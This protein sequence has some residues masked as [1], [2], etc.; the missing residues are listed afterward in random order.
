[1]LAQFLLAF[2][3]NLCSICASYVEFILDYARNIRRDCHFWPDT[4]HRSLCSQLYTSHTFWTPRTTYLS[5]QDRLPYFPVTTSKKIH[6][7]NT[8]SSDPRSI[9]TRIFA[10]KYCSS[11]AFGPVCRVL[12]GCICSILL[13]IWQWCSIMPLAATLHY[14]CYQVGIMPEIMLA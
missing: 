9:K 14:L 13:L 3:R 5:L 4:G 6:P 2:S 12:G 11:P 7:E 10:Q 8:H 1:M